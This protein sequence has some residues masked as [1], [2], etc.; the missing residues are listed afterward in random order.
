M[1]KVIKM[2]NKSKGDMYDWVT[3]TW[4]PIRGLCKHNCDYCYMKIYPQKE[5][6]LVEKELTLDLGKDNTIFI[7]SGTDMFASDVKDEWIEDVLS[8]C[9]KYPDNLYVFQSKNPIR[10]EDFRLLYPPYVF[11]GTTIETNRENN[12]NN[13][14]PR[15]ERLKAIS[16]EWL[17]GKTFITIE[18]IMKFDLMPFVEMMSL[19]EPKWINIGADSKDHNLPEPTKE[20]VIDFADIVRSF[21]E[22]KPKRNLERLI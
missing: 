10:F 18:P 14:P 17:V 20:E 12:L 2:L 1:K 19:A 11:F 7:G 4:N 8:H 15:A 9:R 13:A 3:H 5:I 16:Q 21:I 22:V 6:R